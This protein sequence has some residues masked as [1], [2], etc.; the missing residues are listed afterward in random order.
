MLSYLTASLVF[1]PHPKNSKVL[2]QKYLKIKI[3][4]KEKITTQTVQYITLV[5]WCM[6]PVIE[7]RDPAGFSLLPGRKRIFTKANGKEFSTW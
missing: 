4:I 3:T 7:G 2:G 1:F 5:Q 6:N